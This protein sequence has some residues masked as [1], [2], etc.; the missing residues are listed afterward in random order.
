MSLIE[1]VLS[2]IKRFGLIRPSDLI[3]VGLSGGPDSVCLTYVLWRLKGL[4]NMELIPVY[5]NHGLRPEEIP[6]EIELC[7]R[8]VKDLGYELVVKERDVQSYV[9]ATGLN[10]QEAARHLRYDAL[11]EVLQENK[12][13]AIALGHNADD[14]AETIIMRLLRGTGP[15]GLQ[16]IPPL[17]EDIIRP[18]IEIER[19]EIEDYIFK[20]GLLYVIDSSNLRTEYLRNWVRFKVMPLLKEKNPSITRTLTR[21]ALLFQ[22]EER[23]YE[24]EVTKALRSSISR[25]TASSIELFLNPLEAMDKRLLRRLI[26]KALDETFG[27]R[28][29]D[30]GHVEDIADLVKKGFPG[31]RVYLKREIRV[32]K[33]YSTIIITSEPPL[34]LGEYLLSLPGSVEIKEKGIKLIAELTGQRPDDMGDGRSRIVIDMDRL[35]GNTLIVRPRKR[36]DY[37][38]PF[39]LGKK[40]KIQ[41]FFVD[42]KIPR[43]ERDSVPIVEDS[44]RIV[45]IGG[46]RMD[47]RFKITEDTKRFLILRIEPEK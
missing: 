35:S 16:G 22:E 23:F 20:E 12:A 27:L 10:K 6:A 32:V 18:L 5:V 26:R 36:G 3:I 15:Q 30:F 34:K 39:G 43:D 4:I 41:D 13:Q 38:Y 17:R 28:S 46:Y 21:M 40:K 31:D 42:L 1:K 24:I 9:K 29:L 7:R 25:K 11:K 14:Q 2:T 8:F 47:E 19:K 37:F 44:G 45:W 33:A